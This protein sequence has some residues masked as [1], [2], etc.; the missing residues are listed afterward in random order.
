MAKDQYLKVEFESLSMKDSE[1]L[2]NFC[3]KLNGLV[4]NIRALGETIGEEYV[5]K[6]LL[7]AVPTKFLQ[8]ASAIK[9]F[10][11]LGMMSV[12]EVI[13]S[14]KAHEERL[15]GQECSREEQQLLLMDDE[16]SKRENNS[17]KLLITHEKWLKKSNRGG[18]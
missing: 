11:E 10:G 9:Q 17:G 13:G 4:A 8:I 14:L 18:S 16:W 2:D 7:R 15:S 6:K 1:N 5:L 3:M 12:E